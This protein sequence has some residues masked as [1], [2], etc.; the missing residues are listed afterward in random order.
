MWVGVGCL[1]HMILWRGRESRNVA[2][3]IRRGIDSAVAKGGSLALVSL[4]FV[5]ALR[6]GIET[7]LFLFGITRTSEPLQVA[8]GAA[9]GVAGAVVWGYAVYAGGERVW[10]GLVLV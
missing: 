8:F 7:V 3:S 5:M 6:E 2:Q 9:L 4:V 10:L 1:P